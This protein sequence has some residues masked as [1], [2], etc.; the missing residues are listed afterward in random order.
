MFKIGMRKDNK[1]EQKVLGLPLSVLT[2][3]GHCEMSC[4]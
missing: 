4:L 3:L 1:I 2:N